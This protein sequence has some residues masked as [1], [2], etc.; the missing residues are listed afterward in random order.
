MVKRA[1]ACAAGWSLA[2]LLLAGVAMAEGTGQWEAEQRKTLLKDLSA[3]ARDLGSGKPRVLWRRG[4]SLETPKRTIAMHLGYEVQGDLVGYGG[5]NQDVTAA[6]DDQWSSGPYLRRSRIYLEGFLLRHWYFR[7]RYGINGFETPEFADLFVEWSGLTRGDRTLAPTFRLGQ[8]K[9]PMT[10]DW[11]DNAKWPTFAERGMFST[12]IVPNR[13]PGIRVHGF[14]D[15]LSYQA[16]AFLV[17]AAQLTR[18]R[19]EGEGGAV[20]ARVTG[21][22]WAPK[23]TKKRLLHVG[24][25]GSYRWD[26]GDVRYRSKAESWRGPYVVDTGTYDANAVAVGAVELFYQRDRFSVLVEGARTHV[27]LGGGET[28]DYWGGFGQV[29]YFLTGPGINYVRDMGVFGRVN[30]K[31]GIL[32][33]CNPGWGALELAARYSI[34]DLDS[35]PFPGGSAWNVTVGLNWYARDNIRF[36]L[37]YIFSNVDNAFGVPTADCTMNTVLLWTTWDL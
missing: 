22:P 7:V 14:N 5:M 3:A 13:T 20:T 21:L 19:E 28:A 4:L 30:P 6:V 33:P 1:L 35:G 8:V 29:S 15:R 11:M 37:N 26:L 36:T 31:C 24:L 23:R 16:G 27:D 25:S 17:G 32:S 34:L 12:T 18:G 2:T 9:E 10:M